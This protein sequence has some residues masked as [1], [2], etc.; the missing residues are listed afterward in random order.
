M[1]PEENSAGLGDRMMDSEALIQA[2]FNGQVT[3]SQMGELRIHYLTQET[4]KYMRVML[5]APT[6]FG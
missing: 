1:H 5:M 2:Y 6:G 4:L 3:P